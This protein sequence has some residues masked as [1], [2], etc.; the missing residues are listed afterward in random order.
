M[1]LVEE[2]YK[3]ERQYNKV[4]HDEK[5]AKH[6]SILELSRRQERMRQNQSM[7]DYK[8]HIK[9]LQQ[10]FPEPK[11][12]KMPALTQKPASG[13]AQSGDAEDGERGQPK[14]AAAE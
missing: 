10:G 13:R 7:R 3:N 6:D 1:K 8:R 9:E 4:R 2:T 14:K 5:K 11:E 12:T